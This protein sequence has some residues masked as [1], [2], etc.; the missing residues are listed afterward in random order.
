MSCIVVV[1]CVVLYCV[2]FT[3]MDFLS[4][5]LH[6]LVKNGQIFNSCTNVDRGSTIG[7]ILFIKISIIKL[8][9]NNKMEIEDFL[10]VKG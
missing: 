9:F 10:F 1:F 8:N 6:M 3:C 5:R 2:K 7:L 4:N